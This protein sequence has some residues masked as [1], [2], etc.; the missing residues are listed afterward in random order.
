MKST[1]EK[2]GR[3]VVAPDAISDEQLDRL[4]I[5]WA[6]Y[7]A[8]RDYRRQDSVAESATQ[9]SGADASRTRAQNSPPDQPCGPVRKRPPRP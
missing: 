7:L 9:S 5:E 3:V 4:V 2:Q 1:R 6:R 8:E